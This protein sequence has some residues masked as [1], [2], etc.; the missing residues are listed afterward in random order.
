MRKEKGAHTYD[1]GGKRCGYMTSNM[2][3]IFNRILRGVR[4]LPVTAITSFT[5]YKCNEWFIKHLVDAQIVQTHHSDYIVAPNIVQ[6][7]KV[8]YLYN[9][10]I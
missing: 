9:T 7:N 6:T 4:S 5:F 2:M 1:K 10:N 3:E 8:T